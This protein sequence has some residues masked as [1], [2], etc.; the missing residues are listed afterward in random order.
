[1]TP[2][3]FEYHLAKS[4]D[5]NLTRLISIKDQTIHEYSKLIEAYPSCG[6]SACILGHAMLTIN[7][8]WRLDN[9][10]GFLG[11]KDLRDLQN[12]HVA[13]YFGSSISAN[14]FWDAH[15]AYVTAQQAAD[16]VRHI[17]NTGTMPKRF[18]D[19][20]KYYSAYTLY[21]PEGK[22]IWTANANN[23]TGHGTTKQQAVLDYVEQLILKEQMS[24]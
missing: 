6:T 12:F 2:K 4:F 16:L 10:A 13:C 22:I 19:V 15:P 11:L 1:M 23:V 17:I 18:A 14:K 24:K 20:E 5:F 21:K 3:E 8:N 9:L 7:N